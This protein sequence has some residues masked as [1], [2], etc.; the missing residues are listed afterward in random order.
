MFL[1]IYCIGAQHH[2]QKEGTWPALLQ[3]TECGQ[4]ESLLAAWDNM[5]LQQAST[6]S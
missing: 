3:C 1:L 2:K 6:S 4:L 5:Q